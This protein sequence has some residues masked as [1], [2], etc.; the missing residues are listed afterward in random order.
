MKLSLSNFNCVELIVTGSVSVSPSMDEQVQEFGRDTLYQNYQD[1]S[2]YQAAFWSQ[3]RT[4]DSTEYCGYLL[5]RNLNEDDSEVVYTIRGVNTSKGPPSF[6]V[7]QQDLKNAKPTRTLL[8][9][10][11]QWF[12]PFR[13]G[14]VAHFEYSATSGFKSK[15]ALPSSIMLP[16]EKGV[17]HVDGMELSRRAGNNREYSVVVRFNEDPASLSHFITFSTESNLTPD[18][19]RKVRN[20]CI[21]ISRRLVTSNKE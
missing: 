14:C 12:E 3:F 6:S 15:I 7:P 11:S 13:V 5:T 17:T 16:D 9:T 19:L 1:G 2:L 21:S 18:S 10:V 8:D 4:K 20:Q